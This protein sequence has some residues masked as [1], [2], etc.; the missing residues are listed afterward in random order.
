MPSL[1]VESQYYSSFPIKG[2]DT[3]HS[4][5]WSLGVE[6]SANL[7][8]NPGTVVFS[9]QRVVTNTVR[10]K[11]TDEKNREK[12][13][14]LS[15]L[16][17]LEDYYRINCRSNYWIKLRTLALESLGK[18]FNVNES[19]F[20]SEQGFTLSKANY[21]LSMFSREELQSIAS[22]L[23]A[24]LAE[25]EYYCSVIAVHNVEPV[26]VIDALFDWLP[27]P[28]NN[29]SYTSQQTPSVSPGE[30]YG[31]IVYE[32]WRKKVQYFKGPDYLRPIVYDIMATLNEPNQ[33]Q[34]LWNRYNTILEGLRAESTSYETYRLAAREY[35]VRT[36]EEAKA[37]AKEYIN[38]DLL[39][40][41]AQLLL[42]AP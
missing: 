2:Y 36:R 41:A 37:L 8:H 11:G 26:S 25:R 3:L 4:Q 21:L 6:E 28:M 1:N 24:H 16:L 15:V 29:I 17:S 7:R 27:V 14:S 20:P 40:H 33:H 35:G 12:N 5:G 18:T 38:A 34:S 13:S 39:K 42:K 30:P 32:N 23:L 31:L 19:G 10:W 22:T 9:K